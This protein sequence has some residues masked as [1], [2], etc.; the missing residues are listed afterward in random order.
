M[1]P[2]NQ[3]HGPRATWGS[4]HSLDHPL[5]HPL[6][7][8]NRERQWRTPICVSSCCTHAF[9]SL[10]MRSSEQSLECHKEKCKAVNTFSTI[11]Y[12]ILFPIATKTPQLEFL[13]HARRTQWNHNQ[14]ISYS[15]LSQ[16][17]QCLHREPLDS[18]SA[19]FSKGYAIK[20]R[21]KAN[22]GSIP[23]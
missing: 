19:A 22:D 3:C 4:T 8:I 5:L 21:N 9:C 17:T 11:F 14:R 16:I 6:L 20:R 23:K 15:S 2:S 10:W 12:F 18:R 1:L 7:L 13:L